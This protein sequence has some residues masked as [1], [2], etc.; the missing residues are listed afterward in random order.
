MIQIIKNKVLFFLGIFITGLVGVVSGLVRTN[1][2]FSKDNSLLIPTAHA[3][4]ALWDWDPGNCS[5]D[6][7]CGG[8][9]TAGDSSLK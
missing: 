1:T 3:D 7:D 4:V 9:S 2:N 5:G 8:C 6:C